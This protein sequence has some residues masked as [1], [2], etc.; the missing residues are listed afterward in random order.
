MR[1]VYKNLCPATISA[2]IMAA[3]MLKNSSKNVESDNNNILYETLF[4]FFYSETVL[5]FWTSLVDLENGGKRARMI[6]SCIRQRLGAGSYEHGNKSS[7]FIK[8]EKFFDHLSFSRRNLL[9]GINWLSFVDRRHQYT[10]KLYNT[11]INSL[12]PFGLISILTTKQ[13]DLMILRCPIFQLLNQLTRVF[14]SV[15]KFDHWVCQT[16]AIFIYPK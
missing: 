10:A 1:R 14:D 8:C 12:H 15:Q 13:N 16:P 9:F 3:N 6:S 2:S 4:N 11:R 5:T 7:G